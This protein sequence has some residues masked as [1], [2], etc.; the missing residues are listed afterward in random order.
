MHLS[1]QKTTAR[2]LAGMCALFVLGIVGSSQPAFAQDGPAILAALESGL[3]KIIEE[4][5]ASVV[6]IARIKKHSVVTGIGLG[7]NHPPGQV[8]GN[9]TDFIPNEFGAGIVFEPPDQPGNRLRSSRCTHV[10]KGGHVAGRS[11]EATDE[12]V[13]HTHTRQRARV[14]IVA[15]TPQ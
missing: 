2:C 4:S 13:I 7:E 8:I 1:E 15:A 9:P 3:T 6:S 11:T 14:E 5:E 12:L 10:V